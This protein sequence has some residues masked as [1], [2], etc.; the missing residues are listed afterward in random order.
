M[1]GVMHLSFELVLNLLHLLD[2]LVAVATEVAAGGRAVL[3]PR[4][5]THPAEVVLA[6]VEER[7]QM[8]ASRKYSP[9]RLEIDQD[10]FEYLL[11]YKKI[12]IFK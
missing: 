5:Q 2:D 8:I 10:S 11:N 7:K 6:L 9:S 3:L 12:K 1:I 4:L